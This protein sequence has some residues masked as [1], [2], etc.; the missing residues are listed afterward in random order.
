MAIWYLMRGTGATALVLLTLTVV[1]GTLNLRDR[2]PRGIPRFVVDDLHRS[3]AL[4]VVS[5]LAI[6]VV[7]AVIDRFVPIALASVLIPFHGGYRPLWV[8]LGALALD[9]FAALIVTSLLRA[10]VGLR[11]WRRLHWLAYACW[12]LAL[13]HALGTGTDEAAG[14]MRWLA[15]A[16]AASVALAVGA[17]LSLVEPLAGDAR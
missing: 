17:R 7:T 14:W 16:C 12:P 6:H 10:R 15:A 8:G 3:V 4:L 11:M 13:A 2:A 9:L 1:L 5:L